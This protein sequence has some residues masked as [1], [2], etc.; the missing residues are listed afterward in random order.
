MNEPAGIVSLPAFD[1]GTIATV[2]SLTI[3]FV[4]SNSKKTVTM[5]FS[6]EVTPGEMT[7][8]KL[9]IPGLVL[10]VNPLTQIGFENKP[11]RCGQR[12]VLN[13]GV[14]DQFD[15]EANPS[16]T[17]REWLQNIQPTVVIEPI[18]LRVQGEVLERSLLISFARIGN[19]SCSF[20]EQMVEQT[21]IDWNWPGDNHSL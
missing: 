15:N 20:R 17:Q 9:T 6:V 1:A 8:F 7:K 13:I 2:K 16:S 4:P 10:P 21:G 18:D 19:C 5:K 12:I 3:T 14:A 11:I